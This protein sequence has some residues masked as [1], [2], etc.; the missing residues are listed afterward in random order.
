MEL[1]QL[2]TYRPEKKRNL[3]KHLSIF[4]TITSKRNIDQKKN[5]K[6]SRRKYSRYIYQSDTL[7]LYLE[8][9]RTLRTQ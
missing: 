1:N 3:N 7:N 2:D 4:T 6:T 8:F 9:I 5:Y